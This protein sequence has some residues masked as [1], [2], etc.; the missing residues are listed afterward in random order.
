MP[1]ASFWKSRHG[2][3]RSAMECCFQSLHGYNT[4]PYMAVYVNWGSISS[5]GVLI[6]R[7]LLCGLCT[8]VLDFG[9]SHIQ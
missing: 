8:R 9:N 2:A 4:G 7:A 3:E 1:A 5:V 6:I